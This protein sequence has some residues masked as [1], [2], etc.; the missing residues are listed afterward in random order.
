MRLDGLEERAGALA[1]DAKT[2]M[3]VAVDGRAAGLVAVA[4]RVRESARQAVKSLHE[5]GVETVMLTGD[6][7]RTAEARGRQLGMDTSSPKCCR[8]TKR[9]KSTGCKRQGARWRWSATA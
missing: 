9:I 1:A 7:R 8:R 3:Y 5:L 2:A 4:D 6:N